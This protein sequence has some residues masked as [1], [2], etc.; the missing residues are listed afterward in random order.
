M[1]CS[2]SLASTFFSV[3][4][5]ESSCAGCCL[6]HS[7]ARGTQQTLC[8]SVCLRERSCG[9]SSKGLAR[10]QSKVF[11]P[12][13]S[14]ARGWS[15]CSGPLLWGRY[16]SSSL[17]CSGGGQQALDDEGGLA[18]VIGSAPTETRLLS[19][20]LTE[21]ARSRV[22]RLPP[23]AGVAR[24]PGCGI[25][26]PDFSRLPAP[27]CVRGCSD[28][29][30]VYT[31]LQLWCALPRGWPRAACGTLWSISSITESSSSSGAV[32]FCPASLHKLGAAE[33]HRGD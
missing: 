28:L 21:G 12:T 29:H 17:T 10:G 31:P 11:L 27:P 22:R 26:L 32:D 30:P 15:G 13:S 19:V 14:A 23:P 3:T 2:T 5:E 8:S 7:T 25:C 1:N 33:G 9:V 18:T 20:T 6:H 16:R 24:V 4:R